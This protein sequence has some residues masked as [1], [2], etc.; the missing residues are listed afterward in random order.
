MLLVNIDETHD[1]LKKNTFDTIEQIY[2]KIS[3]DI[4]NRLAKIND[5]TGE[6]STEKPDAVTDLDDTALHEKTFYRPPAFID[7]T[8]LDDDGSTFGRTP[9]KKAQQDN[10]QTENE[11]NDLKKN[12]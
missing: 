4:E 2:T 6:T 3:T 1:Y 11:Q 7:A 8:D 12:K 10:E 5:D 9:T